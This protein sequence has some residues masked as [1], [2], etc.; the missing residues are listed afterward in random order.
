MAKYL[1]G[2]VAYNLHRHPNSYTHRTHGDITPPDLD[3]TISSVAIDSSKINLSLTQHIQPCRTHSPSPL[4]IPVFLTPPPPRSFPHKRCQSPSQRNTPFA[5]LPTFH[6]TH[7]SKILLESFRTSAAVH[8]PNL[9]YTK[10]SRVRHG[11]MI[12]RARGSGSV[13]AL[14]TVQQSRV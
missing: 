5:L 6:A 14:A 3:P 4:G 12:T 9:G 11:G 7:R 1:P 8:P 10:R 13:H 2:L